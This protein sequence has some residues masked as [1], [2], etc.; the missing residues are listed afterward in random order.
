[1][2][3]DDFEA[4]GCGEGS[5]RWWWWEWRRFVVVVYEKAAC[6]SRPVRDVRS[7]EERRE[8]KQ[9]QGGSLGR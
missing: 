8:R 2:L 3:G 6:V 4:R 9:E 7:R 5:W 1:M